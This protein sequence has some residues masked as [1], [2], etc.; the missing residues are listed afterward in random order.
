MICVNIVYTYENLF[1]Y[2]RLGGLI[3]NCFK[4]QISIRVIIQL[5]IEFDTLCF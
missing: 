3:K 2:S 4:K 5:V 1:S